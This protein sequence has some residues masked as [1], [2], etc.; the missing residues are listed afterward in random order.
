MNKHTK[1]MLKDMV[2]LNDVYRKFGETAEA[3]QLLETELGNILIGIKVNEKD[4]LI[5]QD[6]KLAREI[7][8]K[9]ERSTLGTLLK[10]INKKIGG[11]EVVKTIFEDALN[12]R[13]QLSHSFY[14][15]HNFRR[16]HSEGCQIMLKDL[17]NMHETIL[18]AYKVALELSGIDVDSLN[19][20]FSTEHLP[21]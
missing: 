12:E 4:L 14:R 11:S 15:K 19:L 16:N 7:L 18:K 1:E 5:R 21:I 2:D 3:A 6:K 13:N 10:S 17:E 9:I 8:T 20:T